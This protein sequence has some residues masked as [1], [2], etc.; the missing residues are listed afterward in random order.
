MLETNINA[1]RE[2]RTTFEN[3][4]KILYANIDW[5]EETYYKGHVAGAQAEMTK[6]QKGKPIIPKVM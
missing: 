2:T 4:M 3:E 5:M 6:Q 1:I